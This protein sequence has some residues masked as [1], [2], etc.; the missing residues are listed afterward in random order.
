MSTVLDVLIGV[1]VVYLILSLMV[2]AAT[3]WVA[4]A[5]KLRARTL[6]QAISRLLD[7]PGPVAR[8]RVTAARPLTPSAP[9]Q[10]GEATKAFYAH[11]LIVA[12]SSRKHPPSYVPAPVFAKVAAELVT[13]GH[14]ADTAPVRAVDSDQLQTMFN[15]TMERTTGWYKRVAQTMTV[16]IAAA[17]TVL[18]N[19]DT[20]Q[21]TH[22]LWTNRAVREAA[23]ARAQQLAMNPPEIVDAG[24][25]QADNPVSETQPDAEPSRSAEA[26][27]AAAAR[28]EDLSL[29]G[30]LIG[31]GPDY[32]RINARECVRMAAARDRACGDAGQREECRRVIAAIADDP[33]CAV[34][35]S[36]LE[37][38]TVFSGT[39]FLDVTTVAPL[40]ATHLL[41]WVLTIAAISFG[42]PCWF[43]LLNRFLNIRGA[44]KPPAEP[45]KPAGR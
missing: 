44:G 1:I 23:V 36:R 16:M 22:A 26:A 8:P 30:Q 15:D 33:R 20:L 12:L 3:E 10:P 7:P 32:R 34:S 27:V 18:A 14:V 41:G 6:Q 43:D 39:N 25:P 40:A 31:W 4:S 9:G 35:G 5:L 38:T 29:L 45:A 17:V 37:A 24:Y 42:A 28:Q 2:S 13:K 19:A 11:P 21:L